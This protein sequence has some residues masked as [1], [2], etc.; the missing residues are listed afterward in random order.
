MHVSTGTLFK[1]LLNFDK[2]F[3][4]SVKMAIPLNNEE[5]EAP[6]VPE[7]VAAEAVQ[8]R[9]SS[10]SEELAFEESEESFVGQ[11]LKEL[12]GVY[13]KLSSS[14]RRT[15]TPQQRRRRTLASN[16]TRGNGKSYC[17]QKSK[18]SKFYG[19]THTTIRDR[20]INCVTFLCQ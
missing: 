4:I 17:F 18:F 5:E 11:L 10:E 9:E 14:G 6:P 3:T 19:N 20:S 12:V 1:L 8:E 16:A 2:V 7:V 15:S 13:G